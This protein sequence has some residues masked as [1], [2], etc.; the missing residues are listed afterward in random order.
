MGGLEVQ[1]W[2]CHPRNGS[3]VMVA[4]KPKLSKFN[5]RLARRRDELPC[6]CLVS[7]QGSF[8][9]YRSWLLTQLFF[10]T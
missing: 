9:S 10:S 2:Y 1:S 3:E 7:P 5:G 8:H 6:G 4:L